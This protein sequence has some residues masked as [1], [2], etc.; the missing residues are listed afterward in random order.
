[1]ATADRGAATEILVFI[2][3]LAFLPARAVRDPVLLTG[4]KNPRTKYNYTSRL[5]NELC[6]NN[7]AKWVERRPRGW[8]R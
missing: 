5:D 3:S 8:K 4:R 6:H 7:A 1:M 2:N